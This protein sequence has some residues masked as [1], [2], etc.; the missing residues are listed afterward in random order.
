MRPTGVRFIPISIRSKQSIWTVFV[1]KLSLMWTF[2]SNHPAVPNAYS[3]DLTT[4]GR[5]IG[6]PEPPSMAIQWPFPLLTNSAWMNLGRPY[7]RGP[8]GSMVSMPV[9][10]RDRANG[11]G[12]EQDQSPISL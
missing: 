8:I 11:R 6:E 7:R 4:F 10:N 2:L 9:N 3:G 12:A 5:Q 1:E